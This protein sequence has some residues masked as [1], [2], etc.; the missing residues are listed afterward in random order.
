MRRDIQLDFRAGKPDGGEP[1]RRTT[2]A[3]S[4]SY[5]GAEPQT[6]AQVANTLASFYVEENLK[7]RER[8]AT[9]TAEFLRGPAR[10]GQGAARRAGEAGQRVQEALHGRAAAGATRSTS[11]RSSGSTPSSASTATA[12]RG[13]LERREALARQMADA[14]CGRRTGRRRG[15]APTP[16]GAPAP[17]PA[18]RLA[19]LRQEL[20]ELR[21]RYS[22]RYPDVIRARAEI[23]ELERQAAEAPDRGRPDAAPA[24]APAAPS[25]RRRIPQLPPDCGRPSPRRRPELKIL[26]AEE[27][28]ASRSDRRATSGAVQ[29]T[30]VREQEFKELARDYESTRELYA[31]LLK[32]YAESQ[33]AESME[34]RQKGEQFR[35]IEPAVAAGG[36]RGAQP[37]SAPGRGLALAAGAAL[38]AGP[39]RRAAQHRASTRSTICGP[40]RGP[41]AGR[42]S[43]GS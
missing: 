3:F 38:G 5:L 8:Q 24:E 31:S 6:V 26:K 20:A 35:V 42:D 28:A 33:I 14:G 10:A 27:R 11:P 12:R 39:P 21:T 43:R 29:E 16:A 25:R 4:L 37:A 18:V 23:A 19:Q 1:G 30:P 34:Q 36:P 13:S 7:V 32:R 2:V 22:D 41:G 17:G 40:S 15:P 9:G